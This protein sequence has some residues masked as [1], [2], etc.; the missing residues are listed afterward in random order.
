MKKGYSLIIISMVI[1]LVI[2]IIV[3]AGIYFSDPLSVYNL[4]ETI[5]MQ[6]KVEPVLSEFLL[7]A[8][9]LCEEKTIINFN[10]MPDS[11]GIAEIK[12]PLSYNTIDNATGSCYFNAKF[13]NEEKKSR[14]FIISKELKLIL[15]TDSF[16]ANPGDEIIIEGETYKMSGQRSNGEL[17]VNIPLL[18]FG[19]DDET[20]LNNGINIT[21]NN[22][23]KSGAN[24]GM[25]YTNIENGTF[26]LRINIPK[27]TP[28]GDYR[29]DA[30]AYEY[31][32]DGRITNLVE[33]HG[34]LKIFQ[35]LSSVNIA[36]NNQ[37]LNPGE[38]LTFEPE[39][40]DQS[41]FEIND[42]V[43]IVIKS[44]QGE[45][46]FEKI[47]KSGEI[48]SF[49]LPTNLTSEYYTIHLSKDSFNSNKKFYVNEK[50]IAL[51]EIIND[52]LIITNIGNI[53][54]NKSV[55][56]SLNGKPFLRNLDLNLGKSKQYKLTGI[57]ENYVVLVSDGETE[58]R[59]ENVFLSGPSN[60]I[61][62]AS[63]GVNDLDETRNSLLKSPILWGFIILLLI[64]GLFF[65]IKNTIKKRSIAFPGQENRFFK[66]KKPGFLDLS[67]KQE[68]TKNIGIFSSN[69]VDNKKSL[70]SPGC[71]I[72]KT[73]M[74][75]SNMPSTSIPAGIIKQNASLGIAEQSLV[76][77]GSKNNVTIIVLKLKNSLNRSSKDI[78]EKYKEKIIS[79]KGAIYEQNE[80]RYFIFSP[81]L[82]KTF[83]NEKTAVKIAMKISEDL[84][85]YN[86]KFSDKIYFGIAIGSGE[87]INK[88][89]DKKLKFTGLGNVLPATKK[90]AEISNG[91][92]LIL[93]SVY[94]KCLSEIKAEQITS[95]GNNYYLVRQVLDSDK[96][97][98]F[99]NEF[100][101]RQGSESV[102]RINLLTNNSE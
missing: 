26:N 82:T 18:K 99:L 7:K 40:L 96:N 72:S 55:E 38:E 51:F 54:Y 34:S 35:V 24:A 90:L 89:E 1:V 59:K 12:L 91:E 88:I 60:G 53:Q 98:K 28:A 81:I 32:S 3:S 57:N 75:N 85:S 68:D 23:L 100:L 22:E 21:E 50:A 56:I 29:I 78:I 67:K 70:S 87:I 44:E 37:N 73:S 63:V 69:V 93:K 33:N 31:S 49:K 6:I 94:E 101:K 13:S 77:E 97:K 79:N 83:N 10:L 86:K 52:S 45:R 16:Y 76:M 65:F 30:K 47:V 71:I 46:I 2:P 61:M 20:V 17:E 15:L 4:G 66:S 95:G 80:F 41:G 62:G 58:L 92:L 74:D 102:N 27:D 48:T 84:L 25:Y 11:S 5:T 43:G 14:V 8:D 42:N 36:I 9:L 39:L 64:G 19:T